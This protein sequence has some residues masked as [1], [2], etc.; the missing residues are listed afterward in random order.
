MQTGSRCSDCPGFLGKKSL[1]AFAVF[2]V[3]LVIPSNIW[4]KWNPAAGQKNIFRILPAAEVKIKSNLHLAINKKLQQFRFK[5]VVE[6][7][8]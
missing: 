2:R 5:V 6:K 1:I 3:V 4:R 8:A 7:K